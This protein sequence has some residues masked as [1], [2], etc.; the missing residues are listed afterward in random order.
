M[1][2]MSFIYKDIFSKCSECLWVWKH[3]CV[4]FWPHFEKQNGCH[5]QLFEYHKDAL[6]LEILLLAS[7]NLHKRSMARKA[8]LIAILA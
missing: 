8:T 7:S 5:S 3:V 1:Q 6:N 2:G 4:K